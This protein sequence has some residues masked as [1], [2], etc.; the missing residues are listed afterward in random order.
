MDLTTVAQHLAQFYRLVGSES[1][2]L[3]LTEQGEATDEVGYIYL[4]RGSRKAQRW[5][6]K[7]GYDGWRKRSSALTFSGADATDGGRY[8]TR[9]ADF[10]RAWGNRRF[11]CLVEPN[12]K[13]WGRQIDPEQ[14]ELRGNYFYFRGEQLWITRLASPPST[15]YLDYHYLHPEWDGDLDDADIDFPLEVRALIPAE[16]AAVAMQ[17]NWL[18]GGPEMKQGIEQARREARMEADDYA[19][20]TKEP[21]RFQSPVRFA[22]HW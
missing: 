13:R 22:N 12:G 5:L 8:L 16:A 2:D 7:R 11:S 15:L 14:E 17:D 1:G 21:R 20:P 4:T 9:P 18:P 3:A 10:L 6:L 19:R